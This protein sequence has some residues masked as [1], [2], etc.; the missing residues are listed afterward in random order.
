MPEPKDGWLVMLMS[1]G[2]ERNRM[3]PHGC[4]RRGVQLLLGLAK[5]DEALSCEKASGLIA[6]RDDDMFDVYLSTPPTYIWQDVPM[7]TKDAWAM[8]AALGALD[9]KFRFAGQMSDLGSNTRGR[10]LL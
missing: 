7:P 8:G 10:V 3:S 9:I 4:M 6:A 5:L 1:G 2:A